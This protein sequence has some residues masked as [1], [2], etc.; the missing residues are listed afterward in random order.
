LAAIGLS[1]SSRSNISIK[2]TK[3]LDNEIYNY[4]DPFQS[5]KTGS[6][7][8]TNVNYEGTLIEGNHFYVDSKIYTD[9]RGNL[10]TLGSCSY[11]ENAIDLKSGSE[12]SNNKMII[13]KNKMWG[14]RK[15][16]RTGSGMSDQGIAIVI[17]YNVNNVVIDNNLIFD[18]ANSIVSGDK[19]NGYAMQNAEISNN[20][21]YNIKGRAFYIGQAKNID[22]LNNIFK[23]T[24]SKGTYWGV[25]DVV[26]N[27]KFK[28]NII[29]STSPHYKSFYSTNKGIY[30]KNLV[31]G[32]EIPFDT[33]FTQLSNDPTS[34]YKDLTFVTDRYTN[35][36][37]TITVP[38][39]LKP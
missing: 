31:Y 20:I 30:S 5:I 2:N 10:N 12:N 26:R 15:S 3:I 29:S 32:E 35:S 37:R 33:G 8:Q 34:N 7:N 18:S 14:Y 16:D 17:H 11:S 6:A 39:I 27:L 9:C 36:P 25:M 13:R 24:S 38:K 19:R 4:N 1:N 23:N 28:N 21:F 22:M